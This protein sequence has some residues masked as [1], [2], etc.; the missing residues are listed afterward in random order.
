MQIFGL[1]FNIRKQTA[2]EPN[3]HRLPVQWDDCSCPVFP[4]AWTLGTCEVSVPLQTDHCMSVVSSGTGSKQGDKKQLSCWGDA[5]CSPVVPSEHRL[6]P[7]THCLN[8]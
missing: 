2:L 6:D 1:S 3:A 8:C 5:V 4:L 7:T